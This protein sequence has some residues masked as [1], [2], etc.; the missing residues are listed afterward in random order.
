MCAVFIRNT[1][2]CSVHIHVV[3]MHACIRM[4]AYACMHACIRMH[5]CS[6]HIQYTYQALKLIFQEASLVLMP[7]HALGGSA[8]GEEAHWTLLAVEPHNARVRYY[9]TL[10]VPS[11][12]NMSV[13][14]SVLDLVGATP[15]EGLQVRNHAGQ[16]PLECGFAV[17]WYLEEE[18]RC[19]AGEGW[20]S[21]GESPSHAQWSLTRRHMRQVCLKVQEGHVK[22]LAQG[23][24]LLKAKATKDFEKQRLADQIDLIKQQEAILA[25]LQEVAKRNL[26]TKKPG[27]PDFPPL[28]LE[29]KKKDI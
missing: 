7:V 13:A 20:G 2:V 8:D 28:F 3:C 26:A 15:P 9:D 21:R 10:K 11:P 18:A 12:Y 14:S 1:H 17:I 23:E 6:V 4:H 25:S 24:A 16:G 22:V 27:A 29:K 5:A 19:H